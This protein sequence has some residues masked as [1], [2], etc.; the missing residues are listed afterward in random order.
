MEAGSA[1][2][3]LSVLMKKN[4]SELHI[5]RTSV[6]FCFDKVVLRTFAIIRQSF[7]SCLHLLSFMLCLCT[8][9]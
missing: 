7:P 6:S 3:M 9:L 2:V 4:M 5:Y 8:L 1:D